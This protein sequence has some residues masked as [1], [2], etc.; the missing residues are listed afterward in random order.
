M[1]SA[2]R[3]T[4]GN[5]ISINDR[6][7]V[8]GVDGRR[9]VLWEKGKTI[10]LKAL[11]GVVLSLPVA[12]NQRGQVIGTGH[13][14]PGFYEDQERAFLWQKGVVRALGTLPGMKSSRAV[15]INASGQIVG[16]ASSSKGSQPFLWQ[17]GKLTPL[18]TPQGSS[19]CMA[20][21][22]SGS[23]EAINDR[24]QV[25]ENCTLANHARRAFLW[26]K[27]KLTDLGTLGQGFS[28]AEAKA[29]NQQGQIVGWSGN[30]A[31]LWQKGTLLDL[32]GPNGYRGLA[33]DLND[34]GQ[35]VG[36][37]VTSIPTGGQSSDCY[38][39]AF[40]QDGKLTDLSSLNSNSTC[41]AAASAAHQLRQSSAAAINNHGVI[42][43]GL[44][45][46]AVLWKP[47]PSGSRLPKV[48]GARVCGASGSSPGA[49]DCLSSLCGGLATCFKSRP[50]LS[51]D[52]GCR[53]PRGRA[54]KRDC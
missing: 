51:G 5:P 14:K 27:G 34:H 30:H 21:P 48:R 7:Q 53:G 29:I 52:C 26:E 22:M 47:P 45:S 18:R 8:V 35:V 19:W 39:A 40:W 24:G 41:D 28:E 2:Y 46:D 15:G 1:P 9:A 25:I 42:I 44:G 10:H 20:G 43:G 13:T 4:Y 11:P 49:G 36:Y 50:F 31:F 32:G 37:V 38:H 23:G 54:R 6:G 3:Q 12:I 17:N 16:T 33:W